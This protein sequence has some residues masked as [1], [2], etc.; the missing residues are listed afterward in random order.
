MIEKWTGNIYD[1]KNNCLIFFF[2]IYLPM[3]LKLLINQ[4]INHWVQTELDV[5]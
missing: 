2:S 5:L 1:S 4:W 3:N